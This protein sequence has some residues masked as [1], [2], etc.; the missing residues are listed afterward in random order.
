ML[1]CHQLILPSSF[2]HTFKLC[3]WQYMG[4]QTISLIGL[5]MQQKLFR[6]R[7]PPVEGSA[8]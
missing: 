8:T 5:A 2:L 6:R 1:R 7:A 3:P 4:N